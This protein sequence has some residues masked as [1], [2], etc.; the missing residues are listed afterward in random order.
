M[1]DV[2]TLVYVDH[3]LMSTA[4]I[5]GISR[6]KNELRFSFKLTDVNEMRFYLG[7]SLV[8]KEN[9]RLLKL[10]TYRN[11]IFKDFGMDLAKSA[12]TPAVRRINKLILQAV[13]RETKC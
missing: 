10:S 4:G 12:P 2:V 6:V 11:S 7:V 8:H 1:F 5:E 13:G 3:L 9:M